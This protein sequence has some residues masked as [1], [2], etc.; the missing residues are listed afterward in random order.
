MTTTLRIDD[1]LKRDCEAI[2]DDLGLSMSGAITLFL[3]QVARQRAIPFVLSCD[4]IPAV[5]YFTPK[6]PTIQER[7]STA[8]RYAAQMRDTNDREWTLDEINAEIAASRKERRER[9]KSE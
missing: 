7:A 3:K 1:D 4:K 8:M 6:M 2:F 9:A 5:G